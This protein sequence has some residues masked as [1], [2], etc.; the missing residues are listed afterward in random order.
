MYITFLF[1]TYLT[2]HIILCKKTS[3]TK[4][5]WSLLFFCFSPTTSINL[6]YLFPWFWNDI[7]AKENLAGW[8]VEWLMSNQTARGN[9]MVS[10]RIKGTARNGRLTAGRGRPAGWWDLHIFLSG[11]TKR[12]ERGKK[13]EMECGPMQIKE[14]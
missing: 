14:S 1:L 3:N 5:H 2:T 7:N 10:M 11:K 8:H 6:F 9:E 13:P 12:S 4:T